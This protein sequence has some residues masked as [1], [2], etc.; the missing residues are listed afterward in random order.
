MRSNSLR[1]GFKNT[2]EITEAICVKFKNSEL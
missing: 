2:F 1:I